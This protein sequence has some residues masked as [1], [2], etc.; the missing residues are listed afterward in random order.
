MNSI[1]PDLSF[2]DE[3]H[4][5]RWR[6]S[7][8]IGVTS[9]FDRV[10][11]RQ[12]DK[13]PWN[14]IGCPDFCKTEHDSNFGSA[15]HKIPEIVLNGG[16]PKYPESMKPWVENFYQFLEKYPVKPLYDQN[17]KPLIE[18]P[19]YSVKY[20]YA[21]TIDL[22]AWLDSTIYL[23][24]WKTSSSYQK[25]YSLQTAAYEQ[26]F[27]EVFEGVIFPRKSKIVRMTVLINAD[28]FKLYPRDQKT[29]SGDFN[30]F[31]SILNTYRFAA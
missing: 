21:G 6:G 25:S 29:G 23:I 26:A 4:T 24:D 14:P 8:C 22:V 10:G 20:K 15:F 11:T 3:T 7:V 30:T 31:L 2:D 18:Y 16:N 9:L 19:V 17:G 1:Q 5:Y 28:E 27:R 12:D 13:H